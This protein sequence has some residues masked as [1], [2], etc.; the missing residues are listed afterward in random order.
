MCRNYKTI[1]K[2][3]YQTPNGVSPPLQKSRT[4]TSN[5]KLRFHENRTA[6]IFRNPQIST[7]KALSMFELRSRVVCAEPTFPCPFGINQRRRCIRRCSTRVAQQVPV[8]TRYTCAAADT[9]TKVLVATFATERCHRLGC[10]AVDGG[11]LEIRVSIV[12]FEA[13]MKMCFNKWKFRDEIL[14]SVFVFWI[15]IRKF[16]NHWRRFS[17]LFVFLCAFI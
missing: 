3:S 7:S 17:V 4:P 2:P 11:I 13:S 12:L 16:F 15:L 14:F 6:T 10:E 5:P 9:C 8:Y 1:R